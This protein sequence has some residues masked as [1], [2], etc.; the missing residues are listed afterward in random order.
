MKKL[1]CNMKSLVKA[2]IGDNRM[3]A[4]LHG[5][6]FTPSYDQKKHHIYYRVILK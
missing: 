4:L 5:E 6:K 3:Y 2:L 1:V